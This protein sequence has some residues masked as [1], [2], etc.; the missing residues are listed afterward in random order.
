VLA[1]D[2]T[3]VMT[4]E[5]QQQGGQVPAVKYLERA[6]FDRCGTQAAALPSELCV[7]CRV[8]RLHAQSTRACHQPARTSPIPATAHPLAA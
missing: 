6:R 3:G 2:G 5:V 7:D 1:P 8:A 4:V